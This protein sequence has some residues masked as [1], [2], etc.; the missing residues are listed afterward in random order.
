M[1]GGKTGVYETHTVELPLDTVVTGP[2][3]GE[4]PLKPLDRIHIRAGI[5]RLPD[6][7]ARSN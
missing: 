4:I 7:M 5:T 1:V 3:D 2:G 6:L